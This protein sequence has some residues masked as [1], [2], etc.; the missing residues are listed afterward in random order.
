MESSIE[1]LY[2]LR[3]TQARF[4]SNLEAIKTIE[5]R[6]KLSIYD[7][8][9]YI[10]K[11]SNIILQ[12]IQ[13]LL[14][15]LK[16]QGRRALYCYLNKNLTEYSDNCRQIRSYETVHAEK[17]EIIR[18]LKSEQTT[19]VRDVIGGLDILKQTYTDYTDLG[20]VIDDFKH[21]INLIIR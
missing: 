16:N 2:L 14:R 15:Y 17:I 19:F 8:K 12:Y 1:T 10:D 21:N 6:D 9:L 4:H 7:E 3:E 11:P 20:N 18:N 13:P 5:A